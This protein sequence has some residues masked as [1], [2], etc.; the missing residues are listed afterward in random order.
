ML[1][2]L[3]ILARELS[4]D[5]PFCQDPRH[6]NSQGLGFQTIRTPPSFMV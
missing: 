4:T 5:R 2:G 6:K 3:V 1:R